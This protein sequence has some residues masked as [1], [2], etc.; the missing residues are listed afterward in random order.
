MGRAYPWPAQLRRVAVRGLT[1]TARSD[2]KPADEA[3][4]TARAQRRRDRGTVRLF[5]R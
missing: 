2:G 4:R 3:S 1:H 5:V